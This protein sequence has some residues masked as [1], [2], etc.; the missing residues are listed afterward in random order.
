MKALK[1]IWLAIRPLNL[2]IILSTFFLIRA[3][4]NAPAFTN[5]IESETSVFQFS[6]LALSITLLAAAGNLINDVEDVISDAVNRPNSNP[7][8]RLLG[9]S[10]SRIAYWMLNA[11]GSGL[12][13]AVLSA[14]DRNSLWMAHLLIMVSLWSYSKYLQ[15]VQWL[16]NITVALLCGIIPLLSLWYGMP[17]FKVGS[18]LM[19]SICYY[20]GLAFMIT[21]LR[22]VV[23]DMEDLRGDRHA[24][25]RTAPIMLGIPRTKSIVFLLFGLTLILEMLLGIFFLKVEPGVF[26]ILVYTALLIIPLTLSAISLKGAE[27]PAD[28]HRVS[29]LLKWTLLLG[30]GSSLIFHFL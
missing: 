20:S 7:V 9:I 25:Y 11:T 2:I 4:M 24:G 10:Q 26:Q 27:S 1:G 12:G 28:F 5:E 6:L 3:L 14:L 23:K 21:L 19:A 30:L 13:L 15:K 29:T 22:E 16:G 8:N 18:R 17:E